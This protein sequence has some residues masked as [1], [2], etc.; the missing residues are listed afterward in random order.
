MRIFFSV[1][2]PSGDLHGSNLIREFQKHIPDIDATG[3]GGPRMAAAG[4]R[5]AAD[6]SDLAIMGFTRVI[7]HLKE[8][9]N[10]LWRADELFQNERPDAV[11]LIDYPGFNWWIAG[12]ARKHGIPV[13]YYGTPQIWA[14]ARH[15]VN[16]LRRLVDYSLCK[17]PF[18]PDWYAQHNCEAT[19][20]GHPYFDDFLNQKL[21][22]HFLDSLPAAP[23]VTILP[24]S[25]RHEV[26]SNLPAFLKT[27]DYVH[28]IV[29]DV[30][31]AIASYNQQQA[32][33]AA[34]MVAAHQG[35]ASP[36]IYV[37][38]TR[39]LI[40]RAQC[41]LA[42]SG[43]VSLELLH[44]QK[45]T[46]IHYRIDRISDFLQRQFRCCKFITL[47][48]LLTS[49]N[50]FSVDQEYNPDD[51]RNYEEAPFPEYLTT[52][53]RSAQMAH[54]LVRWLT[55]ES[56][57]QQSIRYLKS[58]RDSFVKPGASRR[59]AEFILGKLNVSVS[60]Q[61]PPRSAKVA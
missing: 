30:G 50:R 35:P 10:L 7:P 28:Q 6:M 61:L 33:I 42:C 32:D 36:S 48:N 31:F 47:V 22:S 16:K 34:E 54:H 14:W 1:G 45:P 26:T 9:W 38:R 55:S 44:E 58:I 27:M 21:D 43:S 41:C 8:F 29:P 18:E 13:F 57:R 23:L 4:C 59:A 51:I 3:F 25:R 2:E 39:E 53:D 56:A 17:L 15:R 24:G 20:V 46:V 11:V 37:D 49:E 60:E 5:L 19:Y 52:E 12:R 40:H